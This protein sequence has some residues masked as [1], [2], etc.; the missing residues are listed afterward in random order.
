VNLPFFIAR[1]YLVSKRKKNF[2]NIISL[3]SVIAVAFS[4]AALVIVLSV[5]NGLGD[6]LNSLN[7]S[8]DPPLKIQPVKGKTFVVT[9]SLLQTIQSVEGV[10]AI[11]E[12]IEDYAYAR[13]RDANQVVTIK[14][15]SDNF[16]EQQRIDNAIVEGKLRLKEGDIPYAIIG[17]G[18]QYELSVAVENPMYALQLFY[19]KNVKS[20]SLDPAKLYTRKSIAPTAAFSIVQNLDDNYILVPLSFA[21]ELTGYENKRTSLEVSLQDGFSAGTIQQ[22]LRDKLGNTFQVLNQQEQHVDLYRLLKMEKLFTFLA[23]VLLLGIGSIN[24]F[25]CLM[26]LALDKKKD[27]S[28]LSAMGADQSLIKRIFLFEG[29][30]I[31]LSGAV[32][33]LLFGGTICWLQIQYGIVSMGM[34]SAVSAGYPVKIV[35]SDFALTLGVTTA[36]TMLISWRPAVMAT[37]FASVNHL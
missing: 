17:R 29:G 19:I 24:I 22:A 10:A 31:A 26:M 16:V 14:G 23:F 9:D 13:Y 30:L 11:T 15:L 25:F 35:A 7:S 18:L 8:F 5:F 6:L 12:V 21:Q 33:G 37:R 32:I 28:V 3:L 2:I 36:I 34:T 20:S 4:T 1:R 27:I